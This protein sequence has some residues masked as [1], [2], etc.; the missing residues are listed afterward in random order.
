VLNVEHPV[1]GKGSLKVE[2]L[3]GMTG[4]AL[5]GYSAEECNPVT[6]D[7]ISLPVTW[8]HKDTLS[9]IGAKSICLRFLF[10]GDESSPRLCTFGF[11]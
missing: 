2:V 1:A 3:D 8:R 11:E 5:A 9:G 4:E 6:E 7:G 10:S